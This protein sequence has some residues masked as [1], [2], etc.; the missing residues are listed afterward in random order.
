[1]RTVGLMAL[2]L[3]SVM[4]LA[5][6]CATS[7]APPAIEDPDLPDLSGVTAQQ[8]HLA[9]D[10]M[11]GTQ[12]AGVNVTTA[13]DGAARAGVTV[14]LIPST[15]GSNLDD[16][17]HADTDD[18]GQVSFR[19]VPT[20]AGL[21]LWAVEGDESAS[22]TLTSLAAGEVDSAELDVEVGGGSTGDELDGVTAAAG[23]LASDA[24]AGSTLG[25]VNVTV[26]RDGAPLSGQ[27]VYL[28]PDPIGN[29]AIGSFPGVATDAQGRVSFR[30]VPVD[31][32]LKVWSQATSDG[33]VVVRDPVVQGLAAGQV[34]TATIGF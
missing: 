15:V 12:F 25:G 14:Y 31:L 17:P 11:A 5:L 22:Q 8:G 7:S 26:T 3:M 1:M 10:A 28:I 2:A 9:A 21:R 13:S 29:Q 6:G 32:T 23:H 18:N 4:V 33:V 27:V 30:D 19:N 16:W 34:T 20:I 24:M